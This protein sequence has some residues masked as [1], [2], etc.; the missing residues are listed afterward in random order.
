MNP[1]S[2]Q[3]SYLILSLVAFGGLFLVFLGLALRWFGNGR[4][5]FSKEEPEALRIQGN[6]NAERQAR[7]TVDGEV[8]YINNGIDEYDSPDAKDCGNVDNLHN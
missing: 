2:L 4:S 8:R 7:I 6:E 3:D 1:L 5:E